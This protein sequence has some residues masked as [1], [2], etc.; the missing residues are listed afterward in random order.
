MA[1]QAVRP[2]T[3]PATIVKNV[4]SAACRAYREEWAAQ[5]EYAL[6]VVSWEREMAPGVVVEFW[7]ASAFQPCAMA[8]YRGP[9]G[10]WQIWL[11]DKCWPIG[12]PGECV[13]SVAYAQGAA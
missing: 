8:E 6:R 2:G 12:T 9:Y 7:G 5:R 11:S 1:N 10:R 3:K 13:H 4:I